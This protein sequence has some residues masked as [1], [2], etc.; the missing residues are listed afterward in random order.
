MRSAILTAVVV[1]CASAQTFGQTH[2]PLN[3]HGA[4]VNTSIYTP[5]G[6]TIITGSGDQLV[7]LWDATTLQQVADFVGHT[8]QVMSLTTDADGRVLFS[9]AADNAIRMWDLPQTKPLA[10][11][12]KHAAPA[13]TVTTSG[14]GLLALS[15]GDD[16]TAKFWRL[17]DGKLLATFSAHAKP[18]QAVAIRNDNNM[19]ATADG[20][21]VLKTW[22]AVTLLEI[23]SVIGH[24]GGL[25]G[26]RFT[27]NNQQLITAGRDALIR[28]WRLPL[29]SSRATDSGAE[30]RAVAVTANSQF[31]IGGGAAPTLA[32]MQLS[33]GKVVRSIAAAPAPVT[34]VSISANTT[35]VAAG[36]E[37]GEI[38]LYN[39]ADGAPKGVLFGHAGPVRSL[40][41]H[42]DNQ[43]LLSAGD[44]GAIRVWRLPTDPRALA[45]PQPVVDVA[46]SANGQLAVTAAADKIIRFW[47]PQNGQA[48]RQLPALDQAPLRVAIQ[49]DQSVVTATDQLGRL[50]FWSAADGALRGRIGAHVGPATG[51]NH[52]PT[53][54][55]LATAGDD[56]VAKIWRLPFAAPLSLAGNGGVR[57]IAVAQD[58]SFAVVA[59]DD[60]QVRLVNPADGQVLRSLAA[61]AAA[62][63]A[64][65][66]KGA[67]Q[68]ATASEA[69]LIQLW[70]AADAAAQGSIQGPPTA[71]SAIALHP[72]EPLLATGDPSGEV[73]L[74]H[75]P[76]A[77][78]TSAGHT[79]AV[80]TVHVSAD[81]K[82]LAT[83]GVDK[84]VRLWNPATG[85]AIRTLSGH[86]AAVT[87]VRFRSDNSQL[88]TVD[89]TGDVRL[90][91]PADG[92]AQGQL[93]HTSP[94][95]GISYN[96]AKTH[97]V[98]TSVDGVVRWWKLPVA[99]PTDRATEAA[100]PTAFVLSPNR[101]R[102]AAVVVVGGK[103]TIVVRQV[104]DGAQKAAVTGPT[105][106]IAAI[107]Y[108]SNGAKLAAASADKSLR[109]WT[110]AGDQFAEAAV[111]ETPQPLT[112]VTFHSDN[113]QVISAGSDNKI[114]IWNPAD[115]TMVREIAGHTGAITHLSFFKGQIVSSSADGTVRFWNPAN[116]A[117][118]GKITHG[119]AIAD[120]AIRPDGVLA[121]VG[122]DNQLK[123]WKADRAALGAVTLAAAPRTVDVSPN[124]ERLSTSADDGAVEV[125]DIAT[126]RL[127][128]RQV[129]VAGA[130][131]AAFVDDAQLAAVAADKVL[132]SLPVAVDRVV[133]AG[134]SKITATAA[135]PAAAALAISSE[136]KQLKIISTVDGK[137]LQE[138]AAPQSYVEMKWEGT[139]LA[140]RGAE[141]AVHLWTASA[142]A[143]PA[144]LRKI[145]L[146]A[147]AAGVGLSIGG[148]HVAVATANGI[149]ARY[150]TLDL[151][152]CEQSA[153]PTPTTLDF[154]AD[155]SRL[156]IATANNVL[157]QP[158]ALAER[159]TGRQGAIVG[160]HFAPD[161]SVLYSGGADKVV[162]RWSL[163]EKKT[164]AVFVGSA[165]ALTAVQ[166]AADGKSIAAA[167]GQE[168]LIWNTNGAGDI[169][170]AAKIAS[171]V[172]VQSVSLS[173]TGSLLAS[174]GP[175]GSVRVWDRQLGVERERYS[176]HTGVVS[177]VAFSPDGK[178]MFS[179]GTDKTLQV[180][181]LA[182]EQLHVTKD[183]AFRD[184]AFAADGKQLHLI[185][186]GGQF[187][188]W[189]LTA[190][191]Q[192]RP[193]L[194]GSQRA[195]AVRADGMQAA[196]ADAAGKL[197]LWNLADN[198]VVAELK[199]PKPVTGL[200]YSLDGKRLAAASDQ[201][202]I[203]LNATGDVL[204]I[205]RSTDPLSRI[206]FAADNETLLLAGAKSTTVVK[207]SLLLRIAGKPT[208]RVAAF[209]PNGQQVFASDAAGALH[210][211][212]LADGK[213][214]AV[215]GNAANV[216]GV[217]VS[218]NSAWLA[219]ACDDKHVRVWAGA[220]L[221]KPKW[222]LPLDA[223]CRAAAFTANSLQLATADDSGSVRVWNLASGLELQRFANHTGSAA[224]VVCCPNNTQFVSGGLDKSLRVH[225]LGVASVFRAGELNLLSCEV[226][227]NGT[228]AVTLDEKGAIQYWML[229][230]GQPVRQLAAAPEP[231]RAISARADSQQ[232]AGV[233]EKGLYFWTLN[234]GQIPVQVT[235]DKPLR[236]AAFSPDNLKL[237]TLTD[238]GESRIYG[239][240]DGVLL[241]RQA[242]AAAAHDAIFLSDNRQFLAATESGELERWTYAA[243]ASVRTMTGHGG[244]V[245]GLAVSPKGETL[246]SCSADQSI[247]IW[248]GVTGA[249]VRALTGHQGPVYGV[250]FSADGALLVSCGKDKTVRLWDVSGGRQ[251]KQINV[252]DGDLYSVAFHPDGRRVVAGGVD[253]MLRVVDVFAGTEQSVIKGH[254]DY[255]YR[256]RFNA[257]GTRVLSAGYGGNL[258]VWNLAD[259]QSLHHQRLPTVVNAASYAP[260]GTRIVVAGGDGRGYVVDLPAAAR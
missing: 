246:A 247:R 69:G 30:I 151:A 204:E 108:A 227:P 193:G 156:F 86:A 144:N 20:D 253:R 153:I 257:T 81:G 23:G 205:F 45:H 125:W 38:R 103:P 210:L 134:A 248:N 78:T 136:D 31:A 158:L 150:D 94:L 123:I 189:T 191:P 65:S 60:K 71:I 176:N 37:N 80:Q 198:K 109:V 55:L 175:D 18:V 166:L 233:G 244:N 223:A 234:N 79:A 41:F 70:N 229:S 258:H 19:L 43:R 129:L 54:P 188:S 104:T 142:A 184:A 64:V 217:A 186:E 21:G 28:Q 218:A 201:E 32:V 161:G 165:A 245:Y 110:I 63:T 240:A 10:R 146:P 84:S 111:I 214:T 132:K 82:L 173:A 17:A 199:R 235:V 100:V 137:Q 145:P 2:K 25:A 56:G 122:A 36:G 117:E 170:A 48:V 179:G 259:G 50:H 106:A 75:A 230:N 15:G 83:A 195:L 96:A 250:A 228:Q 24:V 226:L 197:V 22:D 53:Q 251:L 211:W 183:G 12:A 215:A 155:G 219:A 52:H 171:P 33:D 6:Q 241:R 61:L 101:Q 200:R 216:R 74:W 169:G 93:A 194:T 148:G 14:N 126:Q 39:F 113:N 157:G 206:A 46:I 3:G 221:T 127:V 187:L 66:V 149:C 208:A 154:A 105:G 29:V 118:V 243:P 27:P 67:T 162:H 47:N 238:D 72:T 174:A 91:N 164:T 16:N 57:D 34:A 209:H 115:K 172:P 152:L 130:T 92:A 73:R 49:P 232:L 135:S 133:V 40:Q 231:L 76:T 95:A 44:D 225:Q 88:A 99:G 90:W 260:D 237:L 51:L 68:L 147:A 120:F 140:A 11:Y 9:G 35:L 59:T 256:V 7:K 98:T 177:R 87:A 178:S 116:G 26:V 107:A 254:K 181:K 42:T 182:C 168:L 224:T 141:A 213:S 77:P 8:G 252:G 138:L 128:Q 196:I 220:D 160:L 222:I 58:G 114:R 207:T 62:P 131:R 112:A 4:S 1:L 185:G 236:S 180:T 124:G 190:P 159:I 242:T 5:D 89:A 85:A 167:A 139:L 163:A 97:L 143:A 249:Q 255:I 212:T 203:I 121:T 192:P 239:T 119:A 202:T 13:R 102:S